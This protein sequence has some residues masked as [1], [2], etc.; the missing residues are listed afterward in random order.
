MC[1]R[2]GNCHGGPHFVRNRKCQE[3]SRICHLCTPGLAQGQDSTPVLIEETIIL[4]VESLKP[5]FR[6]ICCG[7]GF[8]KGLPVGS[9]TRCEP[10]L[11]RMWWTPGHS[12]LA[13]PLYLTPEGASS[14]QDP[15]G[16]RPNQ[17]WSPGVFPRDLGKEGLPPPPTSTHLPETTAHA[18]KLPSV[19]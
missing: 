8:W 11:S 13:N 4:V 17:A 16:F 14:P 3:I 2:S 9:F 12:G 7:F 15:R 6:P 10:R 1:K 5:A 19:I 18:G